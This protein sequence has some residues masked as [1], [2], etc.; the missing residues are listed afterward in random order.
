MTL[1]TVAVLGGTGHQGRGI[2]RRL[3]RA[4][5]AVTVGSRDRQ[6]AASIVSEWPTERGAIAA[7][8]YNGAAAGADITILAVPFD[9]LDALLDQLSPA[10]RPGTLVVDVTVPITFSTAGAALTPIAEG[11]ATEHVRARLPAHIRVAAAFKT[12]PAH[13]LNELDARADC[14]EFICGDSAESRAAASTL[15]GAVDGLRAV[16]VGPLSRARAIEHLTL[17]AIAINRKHKVH[18]ARFRVAGL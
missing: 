18:D 12:L 5:Y 10:L 1:P 6:R 15:A 8:D 16:D 11:S 14:D 17:L 13:L 4:G 9:S 3:A 2:A 7:D